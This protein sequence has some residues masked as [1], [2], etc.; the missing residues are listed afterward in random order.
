MFSKNPHMLREGYAPAATV[1]RT[2]GLALSTV[3][4]MSENGHVECTRVGRAL[5]IKLDSLANYFE[6]DANEPLQQQV[7]K[8]KKEMNKELKEYDA[9]QKK[10]VANG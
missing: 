4:R 3:H 1:A 5:Y 9:T 10:R 2:L 6:G 8:L 7:E